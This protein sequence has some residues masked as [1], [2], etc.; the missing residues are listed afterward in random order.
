[1][2]LY[3]FQ[4]GKKQ[5]QVFFHM[6]DKK[7]YI[8]EKGRK[9]KRVF[10]NP[11]VSFDSQIEPFDQN[12][13]NRKTSTKKGVTIGEMMEYSKELSEKRAKIAGVDI[14]KEKSIL[15]YE[16]RT[17]KAHPSKLNQK[18]EV[19]LCKNIVKKI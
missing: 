18:F 17:K 13:W 19:D 7:E 2:P 10:I 9:W 8:D 5:K 4:L 12:A 15:D 1:M 16:K 6:T 3:T 14:V 11:Q